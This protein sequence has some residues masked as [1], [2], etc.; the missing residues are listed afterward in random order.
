MEARAPTINLNI[1]TKN[2]FSMIVKSD[3]GIE[4]VKVE[5][6]DKAKN[7]YVDVKDLGLGSNLDFNGKTSDVEKTLKV[8]SKKIDKFLKKSEGK[9][10]FRLTAKS[11]NGRVLKRVLKI[12]RLSKAD[13]EGKYFNLNNSPRIN[14][15]LPAEGKTL[16][17]EVTDYSKLQKIEVT[18]K[19]S[20]KLEYSDNIFSK[21]YKSS[22]IDAKY[23][24]KVD[25]SKADVIDGY[26]Y[27]RV[28][29]TD[30]TNMIRTE[31]IKLKYAES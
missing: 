10:Q 9:V 26:I 15:V 11:Y 19:D 22:K 30:K 27:L 1:K 28:K 7:K 25:L 21:T 20:K 13:S 18:A 24:Q 29:I 8:G 16:G 5:K 3:A 12:E 2:E 31:T 4:Y 17:L 14:Y 23:T 6:Y